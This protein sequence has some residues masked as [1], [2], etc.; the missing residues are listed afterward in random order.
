[1]NAQNKTQGV[2]IFDEKVR[3][4][5]SPIF[6]SMIH[7][8]FL[9]LYLVLTIIVCR[10]PATDL[11]FSLELMKSKLCVVIILCFWN[12]DHWRNLPLF[13]KILIAFQP[14]FLAIPRLVRLF[15]FSCFLS[16]FLFQVF[17]KLWLSSSFQNYT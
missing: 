15:K 5:L 11:S 16:Q 4:Y 14:L 3:N 8:Y 6:L 13:G 2:F 7:I 12:Y 10:G 9:Y 1:M 17:C